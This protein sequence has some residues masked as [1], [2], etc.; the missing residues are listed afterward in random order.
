MFQ[1]AVHVS[2]VRRDL[3]VSPGWEADN[4]VS[5]ASSVRGKI[6]QRNVLLAIDT[7]GGMQPVK[8]E[9]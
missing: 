1:T 9:N 5:V 7:T 3:C 2:R 8:V 6:K 4:C